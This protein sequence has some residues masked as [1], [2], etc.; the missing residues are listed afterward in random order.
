[1][2]ASLSIKN[3]P[4]DILARLKERAA[5]NRRSLQGEVLFLLEQA[6]RPKTISVQEL[7]QRIGA[8]GLQSPDEAT[9]M[10]RELRDGR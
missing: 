10:I 1:M 8:L 7:K 3:I 2:P 4:D 6:V 5:K 9:A